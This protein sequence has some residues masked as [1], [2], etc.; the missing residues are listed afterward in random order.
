LKGSIVAVA[1]VTG[2]ER[3]DEPG[4][5]GIRKGTFGLVPDQR[6]TAL[7]Q[8]LESPYKRKRGHVGGILF[9]G[10]PERVQPS[11]SRFVWDENDVVV[12]KKGG[13]SNEPEPL[14][15]LSELSNERSNMSWVNQTPIWT[16][17]ALDELPPGETMIAS[18]NKYAEMERFNSADLNAVM[19]AVAG[20]WPYTQAR[21]AG[22]N[23]LVATVH[24][25]V[26]GVF[27]VQDYP[28]PSRVEPNGRRK[29]KFE[30]E[31]D[32]ERTNAMRGLK[33]PY[34]RKARSDGR[35]RLHRRRPRGR[36]QGS[37]TRRRCE[38]QGRTH[39]RAR[40][41]PWAR[42]HGRRVRASRARTR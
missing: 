11:H 24:D 33:S 10:D 37:T 6:R 1:Q 31:P 32:H 25:I 18:I 23:V 30:L 27:R 28:P 41:R 38:G 39:A 15:W 7:M 26:V 42:Q 34:K 36:L 4:D 29:G 14:G 17:T 21:V 13:T 40:A 35:D 3:D 16:D 12:T 9:V 22:R 19:E 20:W 2:Y 8:G 5:T